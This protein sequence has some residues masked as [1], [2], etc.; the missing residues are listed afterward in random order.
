MILINNKPLQLLPFPNGESKITLPERIPQET[1]IT[2]RYEG[3]QDLARLFMLKREMDARYPIEL[4]VTL[5]IGY[6]PYS[7][8]DRQEGPEV[9]TL[10]HVVELI[11]LMGFDTVNILEPHSDVTPALFDTISTYNVSSELFKYVF[12]KGKYAG[13]DPEIDTVVF[14]DAG[15]QKRY[16]SQV[17]MPNTLV[18]HKLRDWKTGDINGLQ[19]VGE[20]AQTR[21]AVIID[22]LSSYGGTFMH[23][24]K[25]LREMG[26]KEVYLVVAHAEKSILEKDL[27][28]EDSPIT[29]VFTT[30]TIITKA[31]IKWDKSPYRDK[32]DIIE[33]DVFYL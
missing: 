12:I 19:L 5:N 15:A 1:T 28:K 16:A 29:K 30:D 4:D 18:G 21:I 13:F 33:A 26:F 7:R 8:M 11:N 2:L 3:D 14:P 25:K 32:I 31:D 24:G 22:D 9:F 10:K 27:L 23:T 20:V 6:M 17:S